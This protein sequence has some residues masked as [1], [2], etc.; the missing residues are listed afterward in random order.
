MYVDLYF[1]KIAAYE[2]LH[3]TDLYISYIIYKCVVIYSLII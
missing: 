2:F 1:I 3:S